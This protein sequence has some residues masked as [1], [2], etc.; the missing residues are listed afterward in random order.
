[1]RKLG[2]SQRGLLKLI[3]ERYS[4]KGGVRTPAGLTKDA[5]LSS[6]WRVVD[7]LYHLG[8]VEQRF[9]VGDGP[10]YFATEAGRKALNQQI[11]QP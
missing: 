3:S 10:T 8:L 7:R 9:V 2:P 11:V 5:M 1:M 4:L 6:D